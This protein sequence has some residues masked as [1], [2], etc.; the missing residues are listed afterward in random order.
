MVESKSADTGR[1][2]NSRSEFSRFTPSLNRLNNSPRS[3]WAPP[4]I[5][6]DDGMFGIGLRYDSSGPF[7]TGSIAQAVI[8]ESHHATP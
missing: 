3:E 4:I 8:K 2:I 7:L 6:R 5:E 1:Q